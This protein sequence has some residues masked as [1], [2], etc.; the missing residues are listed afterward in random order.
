MYWASEACM[1][2]GALILGGAS[3]DKDITGTGD[4][5]TRP[6]DDEPTDWKANASGK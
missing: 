3:K 4:T 1:V 2:I 5:A 6:K